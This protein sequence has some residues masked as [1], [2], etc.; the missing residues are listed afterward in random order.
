MKPGDNRDVRAA[1]EQGRVVEDLVARFLI[2]EEFF[3]RQSA[4]ASR[5]PSTPNMKSTSAAVN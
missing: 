5:R 2:G 3:T 1:R 4:V